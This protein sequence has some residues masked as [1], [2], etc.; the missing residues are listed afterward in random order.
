MYTV[1]LHLLYSSFRRGS[2]SLWV[3]VS[4]ST[5]K[6]VEKL[7]Y[8]GS[9]LFYSFFIVLTCFAEQV[10]GYKGRA[11]LLDS[12]SITIGSSTAIR[13]TCLFYPSLCDGGG[14]LKI[15]TRANTAEKFC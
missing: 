5:K 4:R 3:V 10:D 13:R 7:L 15:R 9:L 8:L 1:I 6:N 11:L 14:K 12:N 2:L